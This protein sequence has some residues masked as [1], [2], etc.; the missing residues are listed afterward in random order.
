MKKEQAQRL[1]E[2]YSKLKKLYQTAPKQSFEHNKA[3]EDLTN[4]LYDHPHLKTRYFEELKKEAQERARPAPEPTPVEH[5]RPSDGR[6]QK[7]KNQ[8]RRQRQRMG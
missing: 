1:D 4:L 8:S 3:R 7:L 2:K 5:P 6:H